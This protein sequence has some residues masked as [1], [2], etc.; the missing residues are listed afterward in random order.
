VGVCGQGWGMGLV[1]WRGVWVGGWG[2]L[3]YLLSGVCGWGCGLV[4]GLWWEGGMFGV[5]GLGGYRGC[6]CCF[7]GGWCYD[8]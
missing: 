5:V 6:L 8:K 7:G 1:E 2:C 3:V 4:G